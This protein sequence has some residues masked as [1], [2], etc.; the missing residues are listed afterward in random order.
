MTVTSANPIL[1]WSGR[2]HLPDMIFITIIINITMVTA[3]RVYHYLSLCV[4]LHEYV[5]LQIIFSIVIL[6]L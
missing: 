2:E 3:V 5:K 4:T 1:H 6:L